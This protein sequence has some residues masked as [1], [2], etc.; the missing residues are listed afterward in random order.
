MSSSQRDN[1]TEPY[2]QGSG[3]DQCKWLHEKLTQAGYRVWYD[4][5]EAD[6]TERGMEEGVSRCRVALI[7]LSDGYMTRPFCIKELRWAKLYGCILVGVG[8][9]DTRH[10][11]A[12]FGLE[13]RRAPA[14]L[15]HVLNDVEFVEYWRRGFE[16][17]A[18][19]AEIVR[20][21]G[22]PGAPELLPEPA[23]EPEEPAGVPSVPLP[24]PR[25]QARIAHLAGQSAPP[26][27]APAAEPES[28]P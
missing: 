26:G 13:A 6:L 2:G 7:F 17:A 9:K 20:R 16:A 21:C 23:P 15:T 28:T 19:L 25:E 27:A 5:E 11:P 1:A 14:D 8:E 18:M 24:G 3:Q 10:G 22:P 12:D 4:M